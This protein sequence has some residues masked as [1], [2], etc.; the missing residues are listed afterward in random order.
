MVVGHRVR[1][2]RHPRVARKQNK[3]GTPRAKPRELEHRE[4][5]EVVQWLERAGI[6][7]C[8]VPNGGHRHPTVARKLVAEGVRSG[9]PDLLIFTPPPFAETRGVAVEMKQADGGRVTNAQADWHQSLTAAGWTVIVAHGAA[10]ALTALN[11]LGY[12]VPG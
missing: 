5:V 4:Q 2:S 7:F 1:F 9:V 3:D 12:R 10:E 11:R 8:S 6:L